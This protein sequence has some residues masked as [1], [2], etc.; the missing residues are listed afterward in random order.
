MPRKALP[1]PKGENQGTT[2]SPAKKESIRELYLIHGNKREVA[3]QLKVCEKT[4]HNVLGDTNTSDYDK[5]RA[6]K[7][8]EMAGRLTQA[9]MDAIDTLTPEKYERANA[10][11]TSLSIGINIDKIK[12]LQDQARV[13]A[14]RDNS[15]NGLLTQGSIKALIG[16]IVQK[17]KAIS[18]LG[19]KIENIAPELSEKLEDLATQAEL[20]GAKEIETEVTTITEEPE[21]NPSEDNPFNL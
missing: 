14:E 7:C 13:L 4:V 16:A 21:K 15:G 18:A 19:I 10:P 9:T 2:L 17:G 8:L 12:A 1:K 5:A 11:Q 3:R 20:A 6:E